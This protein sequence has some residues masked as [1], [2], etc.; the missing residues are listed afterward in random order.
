[1]I[2]RNKA[3]DFLGMHKNIYLE[4]YD[5]VL[6]LDDGVEKKYFHIVYIHNIW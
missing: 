5:D 3:K 1:M 4:L 6:I 2:A